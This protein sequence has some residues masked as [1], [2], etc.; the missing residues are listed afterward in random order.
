MSKLQWVVLLVLLGSLLSAPSLVADVVGKEAQLDNLSAAAD[1][2]RTLILVNQA[3]IQAL[4]GASATAELMN[5]LAQL[6]ADSRVQG[7]ILV[8]ETDPAVAAAFTA[9]ETQLTSTEL[10]NVVTDTIR[11]LILSQLVDHPHME[12]LVLVGDDRIIPYRRVPDRTNYPESHYT[13]AGPTTTTVGAALHADMTLTDNFYA[14]REF[15]SLNGAALYIPDLAVGRL[16]ETPQQIMAQIDYFLGHSE[17]RQVKRATVA[18]SGF[19]GDAARA[20]CNQLAADAITVTDCDLIGETW[21]VENLRAHLLGVT[22]DLVALS[23]NATHASFVAPV[24]GAL[25]SAEV[26]GSTAAISGTFIYQISCHAGLNVPP[27]STLPLDWPEVFAAKQAVYIG[28]TGYAWG[29]NAGLGWAERMVTLLTRYLIEGSTQE[30]GDALM[31]AKRAYFEEATAFD[32][33]DE[34]TLLEF[35]LYGLPMYALRT[36]VLKGVYLPLVL[37]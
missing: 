7:I 31:R 8:V 24:G 15:T 3:K 21:S 29:S 14:D 19:V 17:P 28:S 12:Y 37:R 11:Q 13:D 22:N 16:V 26:L 5:R 36:P 25:T 18:G 1:Q 32:V 27:E 20:V 34:K 23:T 35:T 9:W 33:Y 2:T 6:S 4:Y 30:V 10:A